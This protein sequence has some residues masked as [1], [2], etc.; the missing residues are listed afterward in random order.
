[1]E[2]GNCTTGNTHKHYR[3]D[4]K[5]TRL[6]VRILQSVPQFRQSGMIHIKHDEN[7][8]SHK[9]QGNCKQR[10]YLTYNLIY[11]QQCSQNIIRKHN[12]NPERSIQTFRRQLRQQSRRTGHKNRT[13][14]NHQDNGETSH[15]LFR[16]KSQIASDNFRQTLALMTQGK[17]SGKIIVHRPGKNTSQHN[18]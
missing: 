10:I 12:D 17:H 16:R 11:R 15:Y 6:R 3:K 2:T 13:D 18:P 7:P 8:H 1:M 9:Q 14:Q 5:F 4:R